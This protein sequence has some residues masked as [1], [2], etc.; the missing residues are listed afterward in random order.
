MRVRYRSEER[1]LKTRRVFA[2]INPGA[3]SLDAL[4]SWYQ[5][6]KA[7]RDRLKDA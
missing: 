4:V 5:P 2:V 1:P 7:L 3:Y 6:L